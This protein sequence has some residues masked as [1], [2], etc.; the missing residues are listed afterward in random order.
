MKKERETFHV[1][2][3]GRIERGKDSGKHV[4]L[5]K[6]GTGGMEKKKVG[7]NKEEK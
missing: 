5:S 2:S 6:S 3:S 7:G 1:N 4:V